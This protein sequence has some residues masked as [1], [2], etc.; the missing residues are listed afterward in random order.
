M[1]EAS[2]VTV[3]ETPRDRSNADQLES[4]S[5]SKSFR[6][7]IFR[8]LAI[9]SVVFL[10]STGL[11]PATAQ[12][13]SASDEATFINLINQVRAGQGLPPL[14]QNGELTSL[15]RSW[16]QAQRDGVCPGNDY[17]C[18]ANPL[19]SGVTQSWAKLGENVGTGPNVND[20]MDAFIASPGHYANIIDPAFTH[21]GVGVV[22]DGARLY[23][24]HRFM[25]L[26]GSTPATTSAPTTA[27][28]TTTAAPA[29]TRA[30]ATTSAP[31]T[32]PPATTAPTTP[33]PTTAAP[34]A[35]A[36]PTTEAPTTTTTPAVP[37]PP[38]V[39][40]GSERA[41]VLINALVELGN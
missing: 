21:V 4:S 5:R 39:N 34:A 12:A 41:A 30:P 1:S 8:I 36:A 26:N 18:H 10:A 23:T 16:S 20:V 19:D 15:A 31:A 3:L 9:F 22:W 38:A 6:Q 13:Q 37:E 33:A 29:T 11:S 14:I 32:A 28:P 7:A 24:T 27:T 40:I 35:T 2:S 25:A 17:I